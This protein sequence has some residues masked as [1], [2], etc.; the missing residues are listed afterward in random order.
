M[1][2]CDA[3]YVFPPVQLWNFTEPGD[4]VTER[5]V[6]TT[7][8]CAVTLPL[9]P[10][11]GGSCPL[12]GGSDECLAKTNSPISTATSTNMPPLRPMMPSHPRHAAGRGPSLHPDPQT[13]TPPAEDRGSDQDQPADHPPGPGPEREP[14]PR[15]RPRRDPEFEPGRRGR[16]EVDARRHRRR[17]AGDHDVADVVAR[18]GV[19]RSDEL[20]RN[21]RRLLRR[22]L[23]A[24]VI[25]ADPRFRDGPA[26]A[27][28]K[29]LHPDG[30]R[31]GLGTRIDDVQ[32]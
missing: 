8:R 16:A 3:V 28:R 9:P 18:R 29:A 4:T 15:R 7:L 30:H 1:S 14:G 26:R 24:E 5:I 27:G 10:N 32:G 19:G 22:Q 11:A 12:G 23:A 13:R 25:D 21:A 20:E 6:G 31:F 17:G 2:P